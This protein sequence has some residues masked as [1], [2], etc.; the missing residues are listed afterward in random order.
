ARVLESVSGTI[1]ITLAE[2]V[3]FAFDRE[4]AT[5][6]AA[7]PGVEHHER[8]DFQDRLELVRTGQA[9][10]AGALAELMMLVG[11]FAGGAGVVAALAWLDPALL[12][13]ILLA[14]PAIVVASWRERW[15]AVGEEGSA[16]PRRLAR[17]LRRT[18][19]DRDAGMELRVFGLRDEIRDRMRAAARDARQ[20]NLQAARRVAVADAGLQCFLALGYLSGIGYMFWRAVTGHASVGDVVAA[21]YLCRQVADLIVAPV[22]SAALLGPMLRTARRLLWLRDYAA[23]AAAR[24]PGDVAPPDRLAA[25]IVFEDVSFTYPGTQVPVLRNLSLTVPAGSVVALVGVNGAGKTTLVKL[26]TR[27]YEPTS[28]R[29]L[30]DGVHLADMDVIR[31]RQRLAAAFQ[32]FARLELVAQHSVGLGDLPRLDDPDAT[33]AAL[34]RAGAGDVV[35]DLPD[36][37]GTQLGSRWDG[38]VD[39]STGQWQK[40]ALGRALMRDDPLVV[41]FDEPT[42]SLDAQTEHVLFARY[43]EVARGGRRS[44]AVTFLVS[45]RFSTVRAA[46]L[47]VV[48]DGGEVVEYGDHETLM[49]RAGTYAELFTLQARSYA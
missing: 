43:A 18:L 22:F 42:A 5:L 34:A 49:E 29:V 28:G 8:A 9:Q 32:D 38:G 48:L 20:A 47:I 14:V 27:M 12:A 23:S 26:L 1:R 2:R 19:R 37:L 21:V 4:V 45:H 41:F 40:L 11:E 13:L 31:W 39:L 44:G 7:I 3:G 17:H 10:L 16:T 24:R 30:V 6:A 15:R 36:R 35:V 25:G 46:D 33:T